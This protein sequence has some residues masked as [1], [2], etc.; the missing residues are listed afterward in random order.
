MK[1][2]ILAIATIITLTVGNGFAQRNN[3]HDIPSV[4]NSRVDN[5]V[6]ELQINRLDQIVG[7][8]RKQ[9]NKIK[10][11]ENQYDRLISP[12]RRYHTYQGAQRLERQ[13]QKEILDVLTPAQRQRLYAFQRTNN[14]RYNWK[15]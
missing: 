14:K 15:G 8:T 11:I 7:L 3:R 1:K 6:E 4:N 12:N 2:T 10:K 9:E 5:T 13:K